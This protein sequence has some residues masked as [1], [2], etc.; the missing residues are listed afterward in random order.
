MALATLTMRG[1]AIERSHL[2]IKS[3]YS[4]W[5]SPPLHRIKTSLHT[6]FAHSDCVH[7]S[8]RRPPSTLPYHHVD[9][10]RSLPY[11]RGGNNPEQSARWVDVGRSFYWHRLFV[12]VSLSV[13]LL[14]AAP[15]AS[16]RLFG[17]TVCQC[18][19]YYRSTKSETDHWFLKSLVR[20]SGLPCMLWS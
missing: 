12:Y 5:T 3:C 7:H 11:S 15:D 14:R 13:Q 4:S 8:S 20:T 17:L 10:A 19:Y 2:L 16:Y 1:L 9:P 18:F 6:L